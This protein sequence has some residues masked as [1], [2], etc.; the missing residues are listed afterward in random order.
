MCLCVC[1]LV[2][3]WRGEDRTGLLSPARSPTRSLRAAFDTAAEDKTPVSP[4][5]PAVQPTAAAP[6]SPPRTAQD[7]SAPLTNMFS[8]PGKALTV[9]ASPTKQ[10]TSHAA[11]PA[12]AAVPP[13]ANLTKSPGG[14][15][16]LRV[17]VP[18]AEQSCG[19]SLAQLHSMQIGSP[20][21]HESSFA[22]V[23]SYGSNEVHNA[24]DVSSNPPSLGGGLSTGSPAERRAPHAASRLAAHHG[25][26]SGLPLPGGMGV[27]GEHGHGEAPMSATAQAML[28]QMNH[29]RS[30]L[31]GLNR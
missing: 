21:I 14:P 25:G 31:A 13:Q 7:L 17:E 18:H 6:G 15:S 8:S 12:P 27:D 4:G 29:M 23:S 5:A 30:E 26:A 24:S 28:A 10:T 16:G 2:Q 11:T 20:D 22:H 9:S 19:Y 1:V 3:A